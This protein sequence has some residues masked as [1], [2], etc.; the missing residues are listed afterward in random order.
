MVL[1]LFS[2]ITKYYMGIERKKLLK[3]F[4]KEKTK[5]GEFLVIKFKQ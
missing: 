2:D 3:E 1:M 5:T 4:L